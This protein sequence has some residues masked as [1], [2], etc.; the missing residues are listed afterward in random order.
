MHIKKFTIF[1][2][3]FLLLTLTNISPLYAESKNAP[4]IHTKSFEG[5]T[6]AIKQGRVRA[7]TGLDM[8]RENATSQDFIRTYAHVILANKLGSS[9][10]NSIIADTSKDFDA[11]AKEFLEELAEEMT[12]EQI[13]EAE[14]LADQMWQTMPVHN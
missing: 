12:A 7:H 8:S 2:F 10:G 5:T 13:K 1:I 9:L 6:N 4:S 11:I 3:V 14:E